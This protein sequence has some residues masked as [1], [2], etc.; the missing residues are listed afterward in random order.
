MTSVFLVGAGPGDPDLLT[1]KALRLLQTADVVLHDSLVGKKILTLVSNKARLVDVG[2]RCGKTSAAQGE[3]CRLLVAEAR[4][5]YRVV[6]LKGGDPMVFGRATEE[7]DALRETGI[8][9]EVVPGITAAT[10][11]AAALQ[12]SLTRREVARSVHFLTGHGA[13]GGLPEHDWVALARG[14][15]TLAVYMGAQTLPGLAAHLIE[16]GMSPDTPALAVENAALPGQRVLSGTLGALPRLLATAAPEGPVLVLIGQ[17][18][19]DEAVAQGTL[20]AAVA[21]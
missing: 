3:I 2:K 12:I 14:G 9:F 21:G 1:V 10:A 16:A 17:A 5:G 20:A 18:L 15:G 13:A 6:R 8:A 4:A 19:A 7:M 11:A